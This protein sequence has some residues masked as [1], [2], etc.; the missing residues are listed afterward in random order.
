MVSCKCS[1]VGTQGWPSG[2][3]AAGDVRTRCEH[4]WNKSGGTVR[5]VFSLDLFE[6]PS[7]KEDNDKIF[8]SL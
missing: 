1:H 3:I 6:N 4:V 8:Y 7:I 2:D 5:H